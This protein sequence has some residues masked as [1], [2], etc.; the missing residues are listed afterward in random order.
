M[1][2]DPTGGPRF[3]GELIDPHAR[4]AELE[5]TLNACTA[6]RDAL[7]AQLALKPRA[8]L[9]VGAQD[10]IEGWALRSDSLKSRAMHYFR[11]GR[12]L[13]ARQWPQKRV[14]LTATP[15]GMVCPDCAGARRP[16]AVAGEPQQ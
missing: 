9:P 3:R 1:A 7:V 12:S 13:C 4:I 14:T 10:L 16:R 11:E 2:D 15:K 5:A 6:E 8:D